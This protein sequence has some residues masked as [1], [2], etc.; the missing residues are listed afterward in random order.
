MLTQINRR[1]VILVLPALLAATSILSLVAGSLSSDSAADMLQQYGAGV[2]QNNS[3][4]EWLP[5]WIRRCIESRD[6]RVIGVSFFTM[7]VDDHILTHLKS[8]NNLRTLNL[9]GSTISDGSLKK[10]NSLQSLEEL[11]LYDTSISD[12]GIAML[13]GH[14]NI[15]MIGVSGTHISDASLAVFSSMPRLRELDI[16]GTK[17]SDSAVD[18]FVSR[19]PDVKVIK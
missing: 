18:D 16:Y 5:Y 17:L 1:V 15:R 14:P 8:F 3:K 11:L 7:P 4:F 13:Q 10:L 6:A 9:A 19:R 12:V 2:T